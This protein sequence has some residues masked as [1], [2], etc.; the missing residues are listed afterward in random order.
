MWIKGIYGSYKWTAQ[1]WVASGIAGSRGS[2]LLGFALTLSFSW[3]HFLLYW[4]HSQE[5]FLY[6]I[7]PRSSSSEASNT[8]TFSHSCRLRVYHS[9]LLQQDFP[10]RFIFVLLGTHA[11]FWTLR[12][13]DKISLI[14]ILGLRGEWVVGRPSPITHRRAIRSTVAEIPDVHVIGTSDPPSFEVF[15]VLFHRSEGRLQGAVI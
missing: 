8:L 10:S 5:D 11:V 4:P 3:L 12:V 14:W 13:G 6:M 7:P 15:S 1:E 9:H 2:A